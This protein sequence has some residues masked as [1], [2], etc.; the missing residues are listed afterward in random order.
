MVAGMYDEEVCVHI[1]YQDRQ[2]FQGVVRVSL[3]DPQAQFLW[4]DRLA[5]V[6]TG[7][8]NIP[9]GR[10]ELLDVV[11]WSNGLGFE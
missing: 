7:E 9:Q 2:D 6:C 4:E 10:I 3:I 8:R 1:V 5:L 11:D